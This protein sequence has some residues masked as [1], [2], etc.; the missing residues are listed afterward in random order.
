M[1]LPL[2]TGWESTR[3]GLQWASQVLGALR[4]AGAAALVGELLA[5]IHG[6]I[7]P[8]MEGAK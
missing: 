6:V 5:G 3:D 2:L 4:V 7:V 8:R 1:A